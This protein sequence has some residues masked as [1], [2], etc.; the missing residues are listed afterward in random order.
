MDDGEGLVRGRTD[1][2]AR[3]AARHVSRN[4]WTF[5]KLPEVAVANLSS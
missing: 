1:G 3:S 2:S 4:N 5:M